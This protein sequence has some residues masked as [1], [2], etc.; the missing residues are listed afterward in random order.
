MRRLFRTGHP[1]VG[2]RFRTFLARYTLPQ[3]VGML[4]LLLG[5]VAASLA[6]LFWKTQ[7]TGQTHSYWYW[8]RETALRLCGFKTP[9]EDST[10]QTVR[11]VA[12]LVAALCGLII[13]ALALG[14]VVFKAFVGRTVFRT[15]NRIA[16][17]L[18][19]G[20]L[21]LVFRLYSSTKVQLMDLDFK[22]FAR[23]PGTNERGGRILD[24]VELPVGS[25]KQHWP[26]ALPHVPYSVPVPL[27]TG[28]LDPQTGAL[29]K[30]LGRAIPDGC[31]LLLTSHGRIPELGTEFIETHWYDTKSHILAGDYGEVIVDYPRNLKTWKGSRGWTGWD[32]F[33]A[34]GK[35]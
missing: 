14:I 25:A 8:W 2:D 12:Q 16:L 22:V 21:S 9:V 23:V 13:P 19:D 17:M 33:D 6:V 27:Q 5:L 7:P 26:L 11:S 30:V 28:D 1:H 35:R 24:N 34:G 20:Q 18:F 31:N 29:V 32:D 10:H 3:L 4:V 15:R